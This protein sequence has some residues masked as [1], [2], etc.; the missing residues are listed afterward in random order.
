MGA[1]SFPF[2]EG[3][4]MAFYIVMIYWPH[5]KVKPLKI[6]RKPCPL[7]QNHTRSTTLKCCM[8]NLDNSSNMTLHK[9]GNLY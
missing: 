1:S 9:R 5:K 7:G 3:I 6:E 2:R 4:A 8:L